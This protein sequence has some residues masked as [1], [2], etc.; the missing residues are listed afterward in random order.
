MSHFRNSDT[1]NLFDWAEGQR[2]KEEGVQLAAEHSE[3]LL[4]RARAIAKELASHGREITAD[5]VQRILYQR[6]G[7]FLGNACGSLFKPPNWEFTGQWRA[8]F[9]VSNH[10]HQNRVWRLKP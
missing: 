8:S 3:T 2:Q 7:E 1:P 10:G 5:D 6:T 4:D 9:R